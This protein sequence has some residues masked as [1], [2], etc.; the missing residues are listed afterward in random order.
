MG[1]INY[2][3]NP[4]TGAMNAVLIADEEHVVPTVSPYWIRLTEVP[5]KE[6][7]SS[8]KVYRWNGSSWVQ[9]SEVAASPASGQF[10]PDYSAAPNGDTEWNTGLLLF[11]SAQAGARVKVSYKGTGMA[12]TAETEEML[13]GVYRFATAG[14]YSW[15][16]PYGLTKVYVT[17]VGGGGV[18]GLSDAGEGVAG[19]KGGN[20]Y[21][22][23]KEAVTVTPGTTYSIHVGAGGRRNPSTPSI[24]TSAEDTTLG[25]LLTAAHGANGTDASGTMPGTDGAGGW[26]IQQYGAGGGRLDPADWNGTDGLLVIEW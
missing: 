5:L 7:P 12:V 6:T 21:S 25:A 19:G 8:M 15:K 10:W 4:F 13:H 1:A 22:Y 9:M 16:C 24:I 2:R 3:L 11:S 20:G 18:A 23:F 14:D 26:N 17:A